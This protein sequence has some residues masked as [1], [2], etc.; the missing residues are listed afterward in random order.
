MYFSLSYYHVYN[1]TVGLKLWLSHLS[2]QYVGKLSS[3][4]RLLLASM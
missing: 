4:V 3:K 2:G 1:L